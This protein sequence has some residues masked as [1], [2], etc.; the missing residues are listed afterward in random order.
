MSSISAKRI[1]MTIDGQR[2]VALPE[3][4]YLK[5]VPDAKKREDGTVDALAFIQDAIAADLRAAR[6]HAGLTQAELAKKMG[7]S[8]PMIAR[9]E[10]GQTR[11]GEK[12]LHA[13][14]TACGLPKDWKPRK[15]SG[16][17]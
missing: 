7:K 2:Y 6:E 3:V 4:E 11:V 13:V 17:R 14:L 15:R 9:A 1:D 16:K 10:A 8:Q 5:L 12:Y